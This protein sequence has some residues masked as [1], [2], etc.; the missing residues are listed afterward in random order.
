MLVMKFG[1]TSVKNAE[2][3]DR[4]SGIISARV[5]EQPIVVVSATGDTTDRLVEILD[6]LDDNKPGAMAIAESIEAKH[7][8]LIKEVVTDEAQQNITFEKVQ[9]EIKRL[10]DM[11]SA[12]ERL[13]DVSM[14]SRDAVQAL[15]ERMSA[16]ILAGSLASRGIDAVSVDPGT[17]I[18]TDSTWGA[19]KPDFAQTQ[20]QCTSV[21]VPLCK[22]GQVPV[23]GGF[24]G[25]NP[26]GIITTLGRG[27]SDLTASVIARSVAATGLEFW[28]DV[29]GILTADPR[30]VS[31]AKPLSE[32]TFEEASEL[33]FLG[34]GVLHPASIQPAVEAGV[35]V[36]VRNSYKQDSPGTKILK[37]R[38]PNVDNTTAASIAYKKNQ[39]LI[40]VYST[41]MLGASGFLRKVFEVFDRLNISVDHIATSEVN[42]TVTVD[43]GD[44][45]PVLAK[46][47][48]EVATVTVTHN[49]AIVSV[50]GE[51]LR[52][53]AGI[54]SK[55]FTALKDINVLF[56]THSGATTN[57][58]V[59]LENER[60]NDAITSLHA[61][62]FG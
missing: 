54:G 17:V 25:A 52:Q 45:V 61:H 12:M 34:S 28:K 10:K 42:I 40:N 26:K 57:L 49:V 56:I 62:L 37:S 27:G 19:A 55:V 48:E 6:L 4:V 8:A 14:R 29:D 11:I 18:A 5:A 51:A 13:G 53:T 22:K 33:T 3:V 16:P 31:D 47:L 44:V 20:S 60:L 7:L 15:G 39:A 32:I 38:A 2:A 21:L 9:P 43:D 1:G 41:R 59:V 50:V 36:T 23:V 35:P 58:S 24:V 46:E 30:I